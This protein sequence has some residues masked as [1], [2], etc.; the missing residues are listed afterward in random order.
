MN[1]HEQ[2]MRRALALAQQA[3]GRTSP[4]PMVGAVLVRDGEI[5]GEGHTQ[6]AGQAHAEVMA[7]RMAG[8]RARGATAY[9]TLEPCSHHG[10][11]PPCTDALIKAGVKKVV[12]AAGD[13]N[14]LVNGRGCAQ[15]R[16]AGVVVQN[17]LCNAEASVLN[18]PFFKYIETG[19]PFVTAKFAMTL[20][21]KIA[22]ET[23]DSQWI[24][25]GRSREQGHR[26][27]NVSD[28]ILVGVGTVLADNPR[29]TTRL[30]DV[31]LVKHPVRI[32]A[33]S[34]GR[35]PLDAAILDANLPGRT[36]LATT[37]LADEAYRHAL[38]EKGCE[39]WVLPLGANGHL[40]MLAL[41]R[42][43]G[44][45]QFINLMVE[46]GGAILG[47]LLQLGQIDRVWAFIAPKL[48]GGANAPTP[49]GG[50]GIPAL[51]DALQLENVETQLLDNDIWI[52][53]NV[54]RNE[55]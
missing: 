15:L 23:G 20:D 10:R 7:L 45:N 2:Y 51:R 6:P 48:V 28:A 30:A 16:E 41:L 5:V 11:T 13:P 3:E 42:E 50:S 21:G 26:L 31:D 4:N 37:A 46:G 43:I 19:L 25:N 1:R 40:D 38:A 17:S 14:P 54:Q 29:L 47:S 34:R 22:T 9:V 36:I 49:F 55:E 44:R 32:V 27:R 24:T 52:K 39:V 12:Y 35:T 18:R 53:A 33:D 8:E